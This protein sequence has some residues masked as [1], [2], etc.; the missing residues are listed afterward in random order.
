[1]AVDWQNPMVLERN[2]THT[3]AQ[4]NH[5]RPL[6]RKHSPDGAAHAMKQ[7]SDYSLLLSLSTSKG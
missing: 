7:T 5:T 6:P 3:T 4:I 2:A 1:V